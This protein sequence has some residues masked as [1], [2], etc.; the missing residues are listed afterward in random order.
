MSTVSVDSKQC[1]GGNGGSVYTEATRE[2]SNM[3]LMAAVEKRVGT[4][5]LKQNRPFFGG[6]FIFFKVCQTFVYIKI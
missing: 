3:S 5:L 2:N 4:K 6:T 1:E